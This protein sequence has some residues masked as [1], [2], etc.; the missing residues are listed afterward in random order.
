M[1]VNVPRARFEIFICPSSTTFS[2][3]GREVGSMV[4]AEWSAI[5]DDW[6]D[7]RFLSSFGE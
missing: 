6:D 2:V 4:L 7:A 5:R 1:V 3:G